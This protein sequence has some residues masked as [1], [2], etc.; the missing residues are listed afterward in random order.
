MSL[1]TLLGVVIALILVAILYHF[2]Y[3]ERDT[4]GTDQ[5]N[6]VNDTNYNIATSEAEEQAIEGAT[7]AEAAHIIDVNKQHGPYPPTEEEFNHLNDELGQEG[8]RSDEMKRK[9]DDV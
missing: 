9:L 4:G 5:R 8:L 7:P 2:F 6:W 1:Y 3:R